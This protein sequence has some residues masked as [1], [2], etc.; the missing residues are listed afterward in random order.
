[1][2]LC[3]DELPILFLAAALW[4]T[5]QLWAVYTVWYHIHHVHL[6]HPDMTGTL[7]RLSRNK[8]SVMDTEAQKKIRLSHQ[9]FEKKS[10]ERAVRRE[11]GVSQSNPEAVRRWKL[12]K[13]TVYT[14]IAFNAMGDA[15]SSASM[16]RGVSRTASAS[17]DNTAGS[18]E[19]S[20][21]GTGAG[22]GAD[23]AGANADGAGAGAVS[24]NIDPHNDSRR[25]NQGV[26]RVTGHVT[27]AAEAQ[28]KV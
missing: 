12:V 17:A 24:G 14:A 28:I 11:R 6:A 4:I 21:G 20:E 13:D 9:S 8:Y 7:S 2:S 23:V 16:Q 10:Q 22:A 5:Q 3:E 26:A 25:H 15:Y 1:M 18:S 27:A 19:G